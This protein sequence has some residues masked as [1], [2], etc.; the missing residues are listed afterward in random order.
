[1]YK[2]DEGFLDLKRIKEET[3]EQ[4]NAAPQ[5]QTERVQLAAPS[6]PS[7]TA[8][9]SE[10]ADAFETDAESDSNEDL[11]VAKAAPQQKEDAAEQPEEQK[12]Q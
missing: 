3:V 6:A 8:Q 12:P 2:K 4:H 11:D 5:P 1:M 7:Q 10:N 9:P